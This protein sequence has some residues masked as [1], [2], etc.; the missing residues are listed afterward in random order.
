MTFIE[1]I[2]LILAIPLAIILAQPIAALIMAIV[3]FIGLVF[4]SPFIAVGWVIKGIWSMF[5][6]R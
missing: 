2:L 3:L 5:Y 6:G 1:I 4:I